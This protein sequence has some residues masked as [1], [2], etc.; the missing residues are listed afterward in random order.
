LPGKERRA[1]AVA[2]ALAFLAAGSDRPY[3]SI[4]AADVPVDDYAKF[5]ITH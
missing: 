1:K 5:S 3:K 4:S 2:D